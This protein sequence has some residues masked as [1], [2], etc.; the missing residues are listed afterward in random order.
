MD[1]KK[2]IEENKEYVRNLR[3]EFHKYPELSFEEVQTTKK[4]AEELDRLGISYEINDVKNTGLVAKIKG[5][6]KKAVMLRADIDALNV[7][8]KNDVEYKSMVKNKMHACGHDAH[9]AILLGAAK[10]LNE[11]KEKLNGDVY[12]VFQPAEEIAEGAKYMIN[13]SN[14]YEKIDNV[15]GGHVWSGLEA[16]KI[17]CEAGYRMAAGDYVKISVTGKS[18][19]GS[20]P[21]ETID[22]TVVAAAIIMN[23]Q[24]V[25]SRRYSPLDE[26]AVTIGKITSGVRFN[27]ISGY[28]EMEGTV[29]YFSDHISD[30]IE[31][32]IKE[33]CENTA[34][35]YGASCEVDY[36]KLVL[37][38]KNEEKS[39]ALAQ[40]TIEEV[41]GKDHIAP[42]K[43]VTG[44]EDFSQY[45]QKKDGAFLFIGT[46]NS[47]KQT[48][49]PHHSERFDV[50]DDVLSSAS[51]VYAKYAINFL[52]KE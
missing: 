4:I 13:F 21:S 51:M 5:N 25:V 35:A 44:G 46:G 31:Q 27:V 17:S 24:T 28:A 22:A 38:T 47:K 42:M 30:T 9:I 50:D 11:N 26:L 8:E 7:D 52:D 23:L 20:E 45:L 6:G 37:A 10:I 19:H 34:K 33:V 1:Y 29:R 2:I 12:L 3:R 18:G 43:K 14:W 15:L 39:S 49:F 48:D 40:K 32:T 41:L 16:G 36:Q